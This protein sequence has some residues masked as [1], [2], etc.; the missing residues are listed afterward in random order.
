MRSGAPRGF[1]AAR[2]HRL[3]HRR[4]GAVERRVFARR[5]GPRHRE[6][7]CV[8]DNVGRRLGQQRGQRVGRRRVAQARDPYRQDVEAARPERRDQRVDRRQMAGLEQRAVEHQRRARSVPGA[9]RAVCAR[10]R[11]RRGFFPLR[12]LADQ[13]RRVAQEIAEIARPAMHA[14]EP[15]PPARGGGQ[16]TQRREL[17]IGPV[18]AGQHGQRDAAFAAA[19]GDAL[20]AVA[21]VG[22][23]AEQPHDREPRPRRRGFD[24]KIDRHVVAEPQQVREAQ[25]RRAL[26]RG[27]QRRELGVGRAQHN[28]VAGRLPEIHRLGAVEDRARRRRQQMHV[29][30]FPRPSPP[31]GI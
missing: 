4:G 19:R 1:R 14:V 29:R 24:I 25:R 17:G 5:A 12:R 20:D 9:G 18:V 7:G 11:Q 23:A 6:P 30:S 2:E 31:P 22:G 28:D 15:Q 16:R 3:E 8:D 27:R 26:V 21:P 13:M 10:A